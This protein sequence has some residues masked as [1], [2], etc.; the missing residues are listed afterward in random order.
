M[1]VRR[2]A[3][4]VLAAALVAGAV[5]FWLFRSRAGQRG[6]V[7]VSSS[8]ERAR[9]QFEVAEVVFDGGFAPG[10]E[11]WGWGPHERADAGPMKVQFAGY[12]GI[13]FHHAELPSRFG[14]L[15]FRF[16]APPGYGEFLEVALSLKQ[17]EP[18]LFPN[19]PVRR[20]H[21]ARLDEGWS[22]VLVPWSQLN[23]F[24]SPFD[25]IVVKAS[26]MVGGEGALLDEVVLTRA[27]SSDGGSGPSPVRKVDLAIDCNRG[28]QAARISPLIYG[29]SQGGGDT[30]E[31]VRRVGG[32][33]MTRLNWE[34]GVWN[35]GSDWFFENVKGSTGLWD[36]IEEAY[37]RGWKLAVVVPMIGWVAKDA[38]SVGF[39]VSKFGPQRAHDP[40]RPEA[41]DG[42]R[43][44]GAQLRPGPPT[45]TSV[46]ALPEL[47]RRW[48]EMV[49]QRDQARGGRGVDMYILDNEPN[50]WHLTHRDVHP[51]PLTYDELLERTIAY[52]Q[53]VREADPDAVIAGPAEWGW[54]AYFFSAKD[55]AAGW[56]RSPDRK[57]HGG[58]PL[59]PWYLA[60][61]A[62]HEQRTGVRV[63]DVVDVH[64]YPQAQGVY[65]KDARIDPDGAALR[66]RSTRALWDPGYRDESWINEHVNLIPRVRDWIEKNYPGR[67]ISLGEWSFGAEEHISGGLAIAEALG[68]FGQQGLMA[69]FYWGKPAPGTPAFNA[70]RAYRNFDGKGAH[71]LDWS[72]PTREAAGVSL[73]ASRDDRGSHLVAVVLNLDPIFAVQT[74][75]DISAC[76]R[77]A[78]RR[79][80]TYGT[81]SSALTEQ[82]AKTSR[83][84]ELD[85]VLSPYSLAVIE[86]TMVQ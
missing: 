79:V 47:I 85:P 23:P 64:F 75:I 26:R 60:R 78:A 33:A 86:L 9:T 19:V 81:D 51:A 45:M 34:L 5:A 40:E 28:K 18:K 57:A 22:E 55:S 58:V 25:R 50:L 13:I 10:W 74:A 3:W 16:R 71:F 37:G 59:L 73:F 43:P 7:L 1:T 70:F 72:L 41:G 21:V 82:V 66:L 31:T 12:G 69:A 84:A 46:A 17:G 44:D 54:S 35:T 27:P 4:V 56:L 62:E 29:I 6:S 39:P 36:W 49:R 80:F 30:G 83:D 53:A 77:V 2:I 42:F 24:R 11:D 76:G 38:T 52:G 61:L 8:E 63:L 67:R 32:N 15:V 48:V 20:E 65:G 14:A 68:R